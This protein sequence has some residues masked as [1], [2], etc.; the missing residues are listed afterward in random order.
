[1]SLINDLRALILVLIVFADELTQV[2]YAKHGIHFRPMSALSR[3]RTLIPLVVVVKLV[4][5]VRSGISN[6]GRY[7]RPNQMGAVD[8]RARTSS[9]EQCSKSL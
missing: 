6:Y 4:C 1:M 8:V 7:E 3:F 2:T 5:G 9:V